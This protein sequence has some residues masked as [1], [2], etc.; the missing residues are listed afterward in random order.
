MNWDRGCNWVILQSEHAE[1]RVR[2]RFAS[3]KLTLEEVVAV[4]KGIP[5]FAHSTPTELRA[6]VAAAGELDLGV[7]PRL[8]A[9]IMAGEARDAGLTADV[10]HSVRVSTVIMEQD[11]KYILLIE[12]S[13]EHD[14]VVEEM[15]AAGV[16][17]RHMT[18]D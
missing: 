17:I 18:T 3:P 4:R 2:I 11:H 7:F 6:L 16:P 12:D 1:G 9:G 15:I 13:D 14:R 8:Q 5:R 10:E